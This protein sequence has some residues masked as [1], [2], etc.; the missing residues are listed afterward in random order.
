MIS[1][2]SEAGWGLA[3]CRMVCF[4]VLRARWVVFQSCALLM[5]PQEATGCYAASDLLGPLRWFSLEDSKEPKG[6]SS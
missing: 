1:C 6:R 2:G 3:M 5:G 4:P